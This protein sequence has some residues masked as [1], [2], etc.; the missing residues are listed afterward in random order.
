ML[1]I[2]YKRI[3][4]HS[5]PFLIQ[6]PENCVVTSDV[7]DPAQLQ[8]EYWLNTAR[9]ENVTHLVVN[10]GPWWAPGVF[11][12]NGKVANRHQIIECYKNFFSENSTFARQLRILR[13]QYGVVAIWRDVS[14]AGICNKRK[15]VRNK[16]DYHHDFPI[17]NR[18]A[19]KLILSP[20]IRGMAIQG[21]WDSS[22]ANWRE[23]MSI[24]DT[25]HW[26]SMTTYSVPS[27]WNSN[28]YGLMK[29]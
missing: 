14:A 25:L 2:F 23:H 4:F 24:Q 20:S 17:Y 28:L 27:L 11:L 3:K 26:C 16:Y 5:S 15:V 19:R 8:N 1:P 6:T 18:I 7:F 22:V 9:Q 10:T 13:E 21:I 29:N 12:V